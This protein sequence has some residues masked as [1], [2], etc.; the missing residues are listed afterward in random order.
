[1]AASRTGTGDWRRL[2]LQILQRDPYCQVRW[3]DRCTRISSTVDH[4]VP[5]AAG[6]DES[7][8]NL[9]GSCRKCNGLKAS[10]EGHYLAGHNVECPWKRQ[11][12][13]DFTTDFLDRISAEAHQRRQDRVKP[14]TPRTVHLGPWTR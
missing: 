14:F 13:S 7:P 1:M 10:A 3:D 2:R 5:S 11:P 9:R 12:Q 8:A 4:I 6:G